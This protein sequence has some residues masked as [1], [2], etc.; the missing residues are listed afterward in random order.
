MESLTTG[1]ELENSQGQTRTSD[2]VR[3]TS[4]HPSTSDIKRTLRVARH[5]IV[6]RAM[7][8]RRV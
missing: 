2:D 1:P 8:R 7:G 4:A 6:D 5:E 3:V